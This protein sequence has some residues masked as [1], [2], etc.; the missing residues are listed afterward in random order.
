MTQQSYS[1]IYNQKVENSNLERYKYL[2]STPVCIVALF[3]VAKTLK[4][5]R[6]SVNRWMNG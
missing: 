3:T 5:T 1:W 4:A 2:E 6:M